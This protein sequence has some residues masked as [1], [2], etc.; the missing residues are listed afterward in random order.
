MLV[1]IEEKGDEVEAL[2]REKA[3]LVKQKRELKEMLQ[4]LEDRVKI[5]A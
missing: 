4:N 1:S 5:I 3:R 2:M